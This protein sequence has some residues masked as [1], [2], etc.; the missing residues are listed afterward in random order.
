MYFAT[1]YLISTYKTLA[2][3][4]DSHLGRVGVKTKTQ[5]SKILAIWL[6]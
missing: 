1:I 3:V 6:D 2:W 4:S 5:A